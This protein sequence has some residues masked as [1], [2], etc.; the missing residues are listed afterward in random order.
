VRRSLGA[1]GRVPRLAQ[2]RVILFFCPMRASS[3]NQ[4]SMPSMPTPFSR[5][6]P[7]APGSFFKILDRGRRLGVMFGPRRQLAVV[8]GPQFPAHRLGRN[9]DMVFLEHPLAEVD[10]PPTHDAMNGR[11]RAILH[12]ASQRRAVLRH[13]P[14]RLP[15][16][17]AGDEP[18]WTLGVELENPVPDDLKRHAADLG[19][20]RPRRPVVNRRQR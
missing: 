9:D 5:F 6:P 3:A 4:I 15:R 20:F 8:H 16:R 17:L 10:K 19:R 11:D 1:E 2:R 12:H 18:G 13:Q 14:R 7:G